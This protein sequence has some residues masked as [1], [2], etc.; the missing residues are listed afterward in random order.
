MKKLRRIACASV[1]LLVAC[2]VKTVEL[3]GEDGGADTGVGATDA[4][5]DSA[6]LPWSPLCPADVPEGGTPCTLVNLRCEYGT[7]TQPACN[8]I[9]YCELS[10][11]RFTLTGPDPRCP[12]PAPTNPAPCPATYGAIAGGTSCAGSG[13]SIGN[14]CAYPDGAC[15]CGQLGSNLGPPHWACTPQPSACPATPPRFGSPCSSDGLRCDYHACDPAGAL[16]F[17][18]NGVWNGGA[19]GCAVAG[20]GAD[21]ASE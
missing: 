13:L 15:T 14:A 8:T 17:C 5:T 20:S 6:S 4:A 19:G 3:G 9:A 12:L 2:S 18:A 11:L 10:P 1:A 7:S 21:A 16:A